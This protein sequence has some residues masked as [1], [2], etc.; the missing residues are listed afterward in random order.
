MLSRQ[1]ANSHVVL[2]VLDY[3]Q[4]GS[5]A[6]QDIRDRLSR[7]LAIIGPEQLFAVVNK[8]DAR[9]NPGDLSKD[10]T[11][12]KARN[13]LNLSKEQAEDRV[14]ETVAH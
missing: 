4:M 9:K 14:F 2:V 12:E 3:T 7:H 5:E 10:D 11:R 13:S 6:A 1:L 8:V